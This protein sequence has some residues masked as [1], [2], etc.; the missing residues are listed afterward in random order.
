MKFKLFKSAIFTLMM[1]LMF[2]TMVFASSE[3]QIDKQ[4]NGVTASL[5]FNDETVKTGDREF[6]IIL[7]DSNNQPISNTNVKA[8]IE[9]DKAMD[10]NMDKTMP[11]ELTLKE[12]TEK[13]KYSGTAHFTDKGKWIIKTSFLVQGKETNVDFD[14]D[15]QSGGPNW[16]IIGGFLGAIVLIIVVAAVARKK[17]N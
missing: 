5:V 13:G 14:V 11:T 3:K 6:S 15:V 9:M 17:S 2:S 12:G 4:A 16:L 1:V 10:M 8:T 7:K